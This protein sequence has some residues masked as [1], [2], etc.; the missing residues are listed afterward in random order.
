MD[1]ARVPDLPARPP[2]TGEQPPFAVDAHVHLEDPAFAAD[3][4]QTLGRAEAA[5]VMVMVNAGTDR[6]TNDAT[7]ALSDRSTTLYAA[8]GFHPHN[9]QAFSPDEAT[10]L[11]R[12]L[13]HPRVVAVGEIGLDYYRHH[14]TPEQQRQALEAQLDIAADVGL[15]VVLHCRDAWADLK[16]IIGCW[17]HRAALG[18]ERPRGLLHCFTGDLPTAELFLSLGFLLSF[19]GPLTYPNSQPLRDVARALPLAYL[20]VETDAPYL[21]PQARRG[22]RNEPAWVTETIACLA[23]IRGLSCE[24]T[25]AATA[26]NAGRLFGLPMPPETRLVG[27][28]GLAPL[29]APSLAR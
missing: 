2:A 10:H 5:G 25:A 1:S 29:H 28:Q 8:L 16:A 14:S 9:A 7:L 27:A 11:R 18:A 21:P 17:H 6:A 3:R 22:Q 26:A 23:A 20:T 24:E 4:P 12:M 19:A 15:P 13:C